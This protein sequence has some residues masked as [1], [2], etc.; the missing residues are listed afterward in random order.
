M[1]PEEPPICYLSGTLILLKQ[2]HTGPIYNAQGPEDAV[3]PH[4]LLC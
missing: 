3:H 1:C 2:Y 4:A